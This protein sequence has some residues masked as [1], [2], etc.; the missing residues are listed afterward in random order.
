MVNAI[1]SNISSL[2]LLRAQ[3]AFSKVQTSAKP[4]VETFETEVE[5]FAQETSTPK[6]GT[7]A[8]R[9]QNEIIDTIRDDLTSINEY[10]TDEDIRYGLT[11]GRS[12]LVDCSA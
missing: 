7:T 11:F 1:S 5:Q 3:N 6:V 12:I 8:E 9:L 2:Q 10:V 4:E